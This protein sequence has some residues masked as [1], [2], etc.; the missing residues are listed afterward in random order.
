MHALDVV[1]DVAV[2]EDQVRPA[3][4][5]E[6][7]ESHPEPELVARGLPD[8]GVEGRVLEG[9]AVEEVQ[10][11]GLAGEGG[12]DEIEP[13]VT[14]RVPPV[15]PHSGL[16][17]PLRTEGAAQLDRLVSEPQPAQVVPELAGEAIVGDIEIGPP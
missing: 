2:S 16:R 4:V 15:D 8:S 1:V 14:V 6:V 17:H 9:A 10:A 3:V 13:A 5:V 12:N 11:V 7:E